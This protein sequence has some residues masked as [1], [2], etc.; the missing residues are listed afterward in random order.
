MKKLKICFSGNEILR[1]GLTELQADL[2]FT[3][4]ENDYSDGAVFTVEAVRKNVG[5]GFMIEKNDGK[6]TIHYRKFSDF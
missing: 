3:L 1:K 4:A 6:A 2:P 5:N